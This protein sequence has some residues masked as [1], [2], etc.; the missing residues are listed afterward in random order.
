MARVKATG[1]MDSKSG[2]SEFLKGKANIATTKT[3]AQIAIP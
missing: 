1:M 2:R 3:N